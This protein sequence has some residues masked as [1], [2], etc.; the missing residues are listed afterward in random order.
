[1]S[2]AAPLVSTD[3]AIAAR[4]R[5]LEDWSDEAL[6]WH[7]MAIRWNPANEHRTIRQNSRFVPAP[8]RLL[9]SHYCVGWSGDRRGRRGWDVYPMTCS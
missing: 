2:P 3:P 1:M 8:V 6:Y 5:V 9:R 7:M 4:Q